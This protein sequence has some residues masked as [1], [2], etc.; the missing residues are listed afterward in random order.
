MSTAQEAG[1]NQYKFKTLF[2]SENELN[3]DQEAQ[4]RTT[5]YG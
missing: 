4:S 3:S 5:R 2:V 1:L